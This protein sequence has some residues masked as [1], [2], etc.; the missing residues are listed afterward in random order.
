MSRQIANFILNKK[1][2][3]I[4]VAIVAD[5]LTNYSG[6]ERV[7]ESFLHVFPKADLFTTVFIPEN[8]EKLGHKRV[9]T[10]FLQKFPKFLRRRHQLLLTLLPKA[11]ESLDLTA[12]DLVLSSSSFV[13]KGCLTNPET[14]HICY[15]HTPTRYLW[16]SWQEY[17]AE[18]P[19][20]RGFNWTKRFLPPL[21]SRIRT[22]DSLASKRPDSYI[23]NSD[24]IAERIRK[25]YCRES[26]V[27]LPPVDFKQFSHGIFKQKEDFYIAMG[28]L[29]PYKRFDLLLETFKK[30]PKRTLKIIG[31]GPDLKRLQQLA[32]TSGN[33]EF[34]GFVP[35]EELPKLLGSARAF[36]FPQIEDAGISLMEALA[37]GTPGIALKKGGARDIIQEEENG[38]FFEEQTPESLCAAIERFEEI[39]FHQK[40]VQ[41]SVREFSRGNF[42]RRILEFCRE[43]WF[44]KDRS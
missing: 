31:E 13:G 40:T 24:F 29:T 27:I 43:K 3:Q 44:C 25:Y 18:F 17:I 39:E 12:Y 1:F 9:T 5:W 16:D 15:C 20:P 41:D 37:T 30:M 11:I 4:R 7:V 26:T 8:M 22:W 34:L 6:A 35:H 28:R 36:L 33:I 14:L 23:A 19:L 21:L 32:D 2:D 42:E 10:S 38:L